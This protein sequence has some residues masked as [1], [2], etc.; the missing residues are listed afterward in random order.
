M[1]QAEEIDFYDGLPPVTAFEAVL[2]QRAYVPLPDDWLVGVSDVVGSTKAIA[3]GRYKAVNMAGASVISAVMN[4]CPGLSFPFA[5]GGDGAS[6]AVPPAAEAAV[7]A[8]LAATAIFVREELALELRVGIVPLRAI[9]RAGHD[10]RVA[11]FAPSPHVAYAMFTG[12]GMQ[13][14]EDELKAGRV[15]LAEAAPGTRPDLTGLSCRWA[16]IRASAGDI[17][18]LVVI[19][20]RQRDDNAFSALLEQIVALLRDRAASGHPLGKRRIRLSLLPRGLDL[21]ARA[22]APEGRRALRKAWIVGEMVLGKIGE[23]TGWKPGGFDL[24]R[25][26]ESLSRNTDF[27]KFGDGLRLTVD[28]DAKTG[29]QIEALLEDAERAGFAAYGLHRQGEALMTCIVP[30]YLQDDHLHF[31]DGAGGGYAQAAKMLKQKLADAKAKS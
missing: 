29:A 20:G 30:S 23:I 21:E 19:R 1:L 11:R 3:D 2:D 18:S 5:F 26:R 9:R 12:G 14:A 7:A 8:A 24:E 15:I 17:L 4:A 10:V 31:V 16:P 6:L 27:R 25:Y 13:W 22:S 28:V